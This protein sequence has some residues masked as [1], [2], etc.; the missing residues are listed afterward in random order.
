M[1]SLPML[2]LELQVADADLSLSILELWTSLSQSFEAFPYSLSDVNLFCYS[3]LVMLAATVPLRTMCEIVGGFRVPNLRWMT[4]VGGI[5]HVVLRISAA[6]YVDVSLVGACI[7]LTLGGS[8]VC[9]VR[10]LLPR[11]S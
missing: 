4:T 11:V 2:P 6:S 3:T 5:T 7:S 8:S 10:Q 9:L 1:G